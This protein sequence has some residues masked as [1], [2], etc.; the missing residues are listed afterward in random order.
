MKGSFRRKK[1]TAEIMNKLTHRT[2]AKIAAVIF[3]FIM[4]AAAAA[5]FVG[6]WFFWEM[7]IYSG[8][9]PSV[10]YSYVGATKLTQFIYLLRYLFLP[11][12]AASLLFS[13]LLF[14]FLIFSA[15][16]RTG[17]NDIILNPIDKIPL[18]ILTALFV[19]IICL[20]LILVFDQVDDFLTVSLGIVFVIAAYLLVIC[21]FM[22]F[23]TRCKT[24]TLY[25]NTV[26]F[27]LLRIIYKIFRGFFRL[28]KYIF[29][30]LPISV[31]GLVVFGV[32]SLIDLF[33]MIV[34]PRHFGDA[35]AYFIISRAILFLIFGVAMINMHELF[36]AGKNISAGATAYRLNTSRLIGHFKKHGEHLVNIGEGLSVAL[37]ERMKSE[38]LKT[39]LITNV[40]HDIKTPLTSII[41]YVDLL[42][43]EPS[44]NEKSAEYIEVLTRQS[45]RLK[46]LIE[47]LL[48]ASKASTGNI[49]S[50]PART[51]LGILLSQ[52]I[53]EYT[54][55]LTA[56]ELETVISIPDEPV[57]IF[58]DGRLLSRVF[59]NLISNICKYS[60]PH[61]RVYAEILTSNNNVEVIF[62]NI[63]KYPLNISSNELMERFVRGDM[64]RSTEG[65]GLGL[66]IAQSLTETQNGKMQ[67]FVDGD[68]FKVVLTFKRL[69]EK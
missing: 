41:N 8:V 40:T 15:G 54:E 10:Y 24:G 9:S 25:K 12:C 3:L 52:S 22:T 31:A 33:G 59:D 13:I 69:F 27:M 17:T 48:E 21:F 16:H 23:A 60:L 42:S 47:D 56:G 6:M 1:A 14:L 19:I 20:G 43:K 67:L 57:Y 2:G 38:R 29:S 18:D 64:S 7:G 32:I 39:E 45:N 63:S 55:R 53:G 4:L 28:I 37:D 46:K 62:R 51:D 49:R 66:S 35:F 26:I 58:A 61:S 68:L 30:S 65:S 50:E 11:I 36:K 5:S 44:E 34:F